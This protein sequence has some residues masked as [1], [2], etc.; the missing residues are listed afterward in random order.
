LRVSEPSCNRLSA[1]IQRWPEAQALMREV[2]DLAVDCRIAGATVDRAL[3]HIASG[4][5]PEAQEDGDA[6]RPFVEH[7]LRKIAAGQN[8]R[9]EMGRLGDPAISSAGTVAAP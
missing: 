6:T 9:R 4:V 7:F 2:A 8:R 3:G 1:S 5:H